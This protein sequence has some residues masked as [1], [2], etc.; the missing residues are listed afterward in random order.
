MRYKILRH[1]AL[2][3]SVFPLALGDAIVD[4]LKMGESILQGPLGILLSEY[5]QHTNPHSILRASTSPLV[6]TRESLLGTRYAL[7]L[8]VGEHALTIG[9]GICGAVPDGVLSGKHHIS[10]FLWT[11]THYFPCAYHALLGVDFYGK[12]EAGWY[13][14]FRLHDFRHCEWTLGWQVK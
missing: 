9:S 5:L 1:L 11:H 12:F 8:R 13:G 2:L 6:F 4:P 7:F 3:G 14:T 10:S